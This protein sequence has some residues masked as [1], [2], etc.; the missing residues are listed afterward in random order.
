MPTDMPTKTKIT[1]TVVVAGAPQQVT[2]GEHHKVEA[3][4]KDALKEAG[5]HKPDLAEWELRGKEG[6]QPI[7][8]DQTILAAGIHDGETLF[9][10]QE[11]GGGG[12]VARA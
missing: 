5:V 9:L 6:G 7:A 12:S 4:V 2:V 3:L 1:V 8:L 10:D 11:A